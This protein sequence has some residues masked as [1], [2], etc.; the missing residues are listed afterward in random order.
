MNYL[1][2]D[3]IINNAIKED[4]IYGDITS[5]SIFDKEHNSKADL[6]IKEDGILC[7]R[8]IFIRVFEIFGKVEVNFFKNDGDKV[9]TSEK[10]AEIKGNTINILKAERIALNLLQKMSGI[11]SI[12]NKMIEKMGDTKTK[13]LDTRK[14]TPN[15]RVLEKYAVKIGGGTNH[16]FNLSD[17]V[18]LKDN[19]IKAAGSIKQ[20]V[21]KVR[22]NVSFV[23][24]IEVECETIEQVKEALEAKADIIMLDNM[25]L[26]TMKEA[27]N[28][29]N[30]QALTEASGNV[31]IE[32]IEKIG[33]IGLDFISSGAITHSVKA[34]DISL[35]NLSEI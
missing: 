11:A 27:L 21:E 13:L 15:L 16:R 33:N 9:F 14:T 25:S 23:R 17:G 19:H 1:I 26:E 32:N 18:M 20:A 7:G 22:N 34:L 29:I 12:T 8:E 6:I 2:V 4:G 10:I 35:K 28:L 31:S 30:G 3:E 5:E 24:K